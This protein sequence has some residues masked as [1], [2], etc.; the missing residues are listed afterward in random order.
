MN[1]LFTSLGIAHLKP[2]LSALMLPPVPFLLLI[3]VGARLI[4]PRRGLGWTLLM[5]GLLGTWL[6]LCSGTGRFLETYALRV[7][8]ALP[9]ERIEALAKEF[10][11]AR[12]PGSKAGNTVPGTAIVVLGGGREAY[13]PEWGTSNLQSASLERLRYGVY[14]AR[15]TGL[16]L[17]F[18]GGVGWAQ[19]DG[20]SEAAIAQDIATRDYQWPLTWVEENSRDTQ[21]NAIYTVRLLKA[22]GVRHLIIV[23]HGYHMRRAL[24]N[25]EQVAAGEMTLEAAPMGL[26]KRVHSP[27]L[28]WVPTKDGYLKT[29]SACRELLGLMLGA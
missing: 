20:L 29:Q 2:L 26:V 12:K 10:K 17:A 22:Q 23:T 24:R 21:E 25:F 11:A 3:L 16:P 5:A 13:A 14:L 4:L 1:E 8:K 19:E 18:S 28:D 9:T 7:P 27:T 6:S 15:Q